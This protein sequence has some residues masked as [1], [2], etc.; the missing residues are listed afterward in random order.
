MDDYCWEVFKLTGSIDA[1]LYHNEY[2][3]MC[4]YDA[5]MRESNCDDSGDEYRGDSSTN[6]QI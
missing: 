5:S 1:F 3:S 4:G 2:N 6:C